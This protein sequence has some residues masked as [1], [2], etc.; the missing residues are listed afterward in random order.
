M[1][2]AC[3]CPEQFPDWEGQDVDLGGQFVHVLPIPM[4]MN[5]P[6]AYGWY[7]QRQHQS[8]GQLGLREQWP[9][10]V[11]TRAGFF[12]GSLTR[13][14]H[15]EHSPSRHIHVLPPSF[16]VHAVLHPGNLS[17]GR[18]V[19]QQMQME[20]VDAG[21]LPKELYLCYLTCEQ[22]SEARG[23]DKILFLRRWEES[24]LLKRRLA[25]RK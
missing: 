2:L 11:L 22:C 8:V 6:L 18:K 23:G 13:L 25:G 17:T 20:L 3:G 1:T 5:M 21:R 24:A 12:R 16:W 7:L 19:I 9:G 10:L 14:L 15:S 4:L